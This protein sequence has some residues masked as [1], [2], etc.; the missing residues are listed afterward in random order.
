MPQS[1]K[2]RS[3][4]LGTCILQW[5]AQLQSFYSLPSHCKSTA[6]ILQDCTTLAATVFSRSSHIC[7]RPKQ[8]GNPERLVSGGREARLKKLCSQELSS[9]SQEFGLSGDCGINGVSDEPPIQH[10]S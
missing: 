8:S 9:S 6:F 4:A 7:V 10:P 5:R 2:P 3:A 1:R